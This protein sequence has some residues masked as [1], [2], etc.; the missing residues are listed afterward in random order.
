MKKL[1]IVLLSL[2]IAVI[3]IGF[4]I[5]ASDTW[6]WSWSTGQFTTEPIY[7]FQDLGGGSEGFDGTT[8][9]IGVTV[10]GAAGSF[11]AFSKNAAGTLINP[12]IITTAH[13]GFYSG[14]TIGSTVGCTIRFNMILDPEYSTDTIYNTGFDYV[15]ATGDIAIHFTASSTWIGPGAAYGDPSEEK[16]GLTF[17]VNTDTYHTWRFVILPGTI[18]QFGMAQAVVYK[19]ENPTPFIPLT[20]VVTSQY[21]TTNIPYWNWGNI[22]TYGY[23]A[24]P[25][26]ACDG[27]HVWFTDMRIE[28]GAFGPGHTSVSGISISPSGPVTLRVGGNQQFTAS[29]S[30]TFTWSLSTSIIGSINTTAGTQVTFTASSI[31]TVILSA[32]NGT[33]TTQVS[34]I[35]TTTSAP[36]YQEPDYSLQG[37]HEMPLR[38]E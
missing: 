19:D 37:W 7:P 31:G 29:G 18:N 1:K 5:A 3:S 23:A 12:I 36:L 27:A 30:S 20:N 15:G 21:S 17:S 34:I 24:N 38:K 2:A 25:C 4:S 13:D 14:E 10:G 33:S 9:N 16:E 26:P 32:T 28:A 6:D 11:D 8:F 35:V 22:A